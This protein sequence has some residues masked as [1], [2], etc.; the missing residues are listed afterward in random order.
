[1]SRINNLGIHQMKTPLS[2]VFTAV[3]MWIIVYAITMVPIYTR[4]YHANL[5]LMTIVIP[6]MLRLIV[7]Q[8]PQL[9]VD[10]GFFFSSTIIAF[11]LVEGL[12]R[13]VKTLKGQI[14]DY[15][16]ERRKSLEVSL[17]FLAAF[18]IGA[19]ITYFIGVDKSIYSNMGWEQVP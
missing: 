4:N 14:K 3:F 13:L 8:V 18:I 19:G 9:A 17:L 11:I 6:N 1:M 7:G 16:K 12:S 5:A 2:T 15:G 10:K